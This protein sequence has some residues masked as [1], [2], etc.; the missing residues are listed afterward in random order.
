MLPDRLNIWRAMPYLPANLSPDQTDTGLTYKA[1]NVVRFGTTP[2]FTYWMCT[3]ADESADNS[4]PGATEGPS[5]TSSQWVQLGAGGGGVAPVREN[6]RLTLSASST[7]VGTGTMDVT[8]TFT[9]SA[10]HVITDVINTGPTGVTI[11]DPARVSDTEWTATATIDISAVADFT[12]TGDI[13]ATLHDVQQADVTVTSRFR[14]T[15]EVPHT[16]SGALTTA[17]TGTGDL[18]DNGNYVSGQNIT[19]PA[20]A[21][22]TAYIA[23]PD[24]ARIITYQGGSARPELDPPMPDTSFSATHTLYTISSNDYNGLGTLLLE[25]SDG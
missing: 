13:Q 21:N 2:N 24:G 9:V 8:M 22:A 25:V 7:E 6:A 1:G 23:L 17:P 12:L 10:P 5:A 19:I 20:V 3:V 18:T 14:V 15:A 4:G 11:T 16:F